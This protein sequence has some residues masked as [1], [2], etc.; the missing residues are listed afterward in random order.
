MKKPAFFAFLIATLLFVMVWMRFYVLELT[1]INSHYEK[2]YEDEYNRYIKLK[3]NSEKLLSV[4]RLRE[5]AND[6]LKM[7]FA[8]GDD[9][10][11]RNDD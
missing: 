1:M 3:L 5:Y 9:Y 10:A 11:S 4:K 8:N 7:H 6:S 2:I